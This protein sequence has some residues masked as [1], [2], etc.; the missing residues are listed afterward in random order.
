LCL[1]GSRHFDIQALSR[2]HKEV[3]LYQAFSLLCFN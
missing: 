3:S 1:F 2:N